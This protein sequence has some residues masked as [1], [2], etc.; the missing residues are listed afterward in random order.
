MENQKKKKNSFKAGLHEPASLS[1]ADVGLGEERV[2]SRLQGALSG[3]TL[4]EEQ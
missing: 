3:L 1:E 2:P 4:G